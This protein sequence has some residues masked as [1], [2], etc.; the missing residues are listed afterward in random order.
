MKDHIRPCPGVA[1]SGL[2]N[3]Q[4]ICGEGRIQEGEGRQRGI[5]PECSPSK[6]A[7]FFGL[8]A[9]GWEMPVYFGDGA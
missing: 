1:S 4:E 6:V 2:G 8:P 3:S 9:S 7:I 5:M